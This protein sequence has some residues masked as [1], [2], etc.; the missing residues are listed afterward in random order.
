M[1]DKLKLLCLLLVITAGTLAFVESLLPSIAQAT[2]VEGVITQ[3]TIWTLMDSP[4]VVS[5]NTTI[6]QS[7]TLI[8]EPGVEVK[9]GGDFSLNVEG[10]LSA[11]GEEDNMIKFTSNKD[12]PIE[13]DWNAIVFKGTV[14]SK[15]TYCTV[16]YA[17]SGITIQNGA[18]EVKNSEITNSLEN[19]IYITGDNQ[20]SIQNNTISSN[21]NGILLAGDSTTG[22]SIIENI[23]MSNTFSGIQLDADSYSGLVILDNILSA[24]NNGF[25]VSGETSTY[26]TRNSISFNTIGIFY[27]GGWNHVAYYNDI[28]DNTY[29]MDVSDTFDST[30]NAEYNYWGHESGP[31]HISLNPSGKGNSI[32]GDGVDL[33]FVFFL[34]APIGYI[35]T[36]PLAAL[37]ADKALAPRNQVVTFIASTSRDDRRVDKYF[38]DFGD[39]SNSDWT[40]LSIFTHKYSSTGTYNASVTVM[41]DFGVTSINLANA[42]VNVQNLNPLN[43]VI[44]PSQSVIGA[45]EQI[46]VTVHVTD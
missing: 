13:G 34:T 38:Y 9:F 17:R 39:G 5:R 28:Y 16:E 29:G 18:A 41:D 22:V 35:N 27:E 20:V 33:D 44:T 12:E 40:T 11:I 24:N 21:T 2:Y 43:T 6:S 15:L 10:T 1:K 31:H 26:I 14:L 30:I 42:I 46:S 4:F 8:V 23:V 19:G 32:G 45:L 3:D 36:R 25:Y 37:F 7:A